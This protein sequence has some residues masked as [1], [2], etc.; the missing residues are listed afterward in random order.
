MRAHFDDMNDNEMDDNELLEEEEDDEDTF[1][2]E[3]DVNEPLNT[4]NIPEE[5]LATVQAVETNLS[6][7]RQTLGDFAVLRFAKRGDL[8]S[9]FEF[10]QLFSI[11][12][13][14]FTD[15]SNRNALHYAADGGSVEL[16]EALKQ[17][18]V[19]LTKDIKGL[20]PADIALI[21]GYSD[22]LVQLLGGS[23][24]SCEEALE[25]FA[26]K[27]PAF[28]ISKGAPPAPDRKNSSSFWGATHNKGNME[29]IAVKSSVVSEDILT[30]V[31]QNVLST[32]QPHD[33]LLDG[34]SLP[35]SPDSFRALA[36]DM[37]VVTAEEKEVEGVVGQLLALKVGKSAPAFSVHVDPKACFPATNKSI[38][39]GSTV[40]AG[41]MGVVSA[42]QHRGIASLLMYQ[43]CNALP[44]TIHRVIF[45]V[46]ET[47]LPQPPTA[48]CLIKMYRRSLRPNVTLKINGESSMLNAV[49]ADYFNTDS[50]LRVDTVL[51]E[52]VSEKMRQRLQE[53]IN[54]WSV[55]QKEA[56]E[57][58]DLVAFLTQSGKTGFEVSFTPSSVDEVRST[59]L[60]PGMCTCARRDD[61][62]K[63]QDV[64][65][66][67]TRWEKNE[68]NQGENGTVVAEVVYA[69]LPTFKP[70]PEKMEVLLL[71][72][73][74]YVQADTLLTPGLFGI[75]DSDAVKA[76]FTEC[77]AF[78]RLLY[79]VDTGARDTILKQAVPASKVSLPM[80]F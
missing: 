61:S 7:V 33:G 43:L 39:G 21:N 66:F 40:W 25:N 18:G 19:P 77:V 63:I 46:P 54:K 44:E 5:E 50:V 78:R 29:K 10:A 15:N 27:P 1:M 79:I 11:D 71:L 51:K 14:M 4:K 26:P 74:K 65:T 13:T 55:I 67:R 32:Y 16:V 69:L 57:E 36:S 45:T 56:A 34:W 35:L 37:L 8:K 3:F 53:S 23:T 2:D 24:H 6:A 31:W 52:H 9:C 30:E 22:G 42:H 75:T 62:G 64:V 76:Q 38:A 72:S 12:L 73:E 60:L 20:T 68:G 48:T 47:P 28:T 58:K 59:L 17:K 49:Y 41:M 80:L 70:G